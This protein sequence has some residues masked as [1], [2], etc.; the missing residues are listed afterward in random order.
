MQFVQYLWL[1]VFVEQRCLSHLKNTLNMVATETKVCH[2]IKLWTSF[3]TNLVVG[4]EYKR[5][6]VFKRGAQCAPWPQ[7]QK[8]K[9]GLDRV[10]KQQKNTLCTRMIKY[11]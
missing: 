4:C 9:P 10:N 3:Q 1:E 6:M 8:K 2:V 11:K 5:T 7:D